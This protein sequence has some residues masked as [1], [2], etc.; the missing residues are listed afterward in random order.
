MPQIDV[1]TGQAALFEQIQ[2]LL[3]VNDRPAIVVRGPSGSG[4]TWLAQAVARS[5][6]D[7]GHVAFFA[8]GDDVF[9]RRA[10]FPL[11]VA[12]A[13]E[14]G[15]EQSK[16]AT[17]VALAPVTVI[18]FGG[19]PLREILAHF[20]E[21]QDATI[22][23]KTPHLRQEDREIFLRMQRSAGENR[24][25][26]VCD[27]VQ[28]WDPTSLEWLTL[29]TSG[30]L[31]AVF[32][33]LD[34]LAVLA[35]RTDESRES[36]EVDGVFQSHF[37]H[38]LSLPLCQQPVFPALLSAFGISRPLPDDVVRHLFT[39]TGS[40]LELVRRIAETESS[41]Q[42]TWSEM[43]SRQAFLFELLER[44]LER[45]TD[46]P[47]DTTSVL[48][49]AAII[50]L[51]FSEHELSCLLAGREKL[52]VALEPAERLRLLE[53]SGPIRRFVHDLVREYYL[54]GSETRVQ[55]LHGRFSECLRLLHSGDFAR[56]AEHLRRAGDRR[57]TGNLLILEYLRAL[58][59]G[60]ALPVE[61]LRDELDREQLSFLTLMYEA[62]RSF[63][64]GGYDDVLRVL[65]SIEELHVDALL[66][67][68]DILAA[69]AH[70]KRLGRVD[71]EQANRILQRWTD[72][73]SSEPDV[74]A[75][76]MIYRV[77]ASVFLADEQ[78]AHDSERAL[79][80]EL[81]RRATYD[82]TA[83]RTINHLRLKSNM[84][85]SVHVARERLQQAIEFF[86]GIGEGATLDPVHQAV[87]LVNLAA[88]Y[89]VEGEY[90]QAFVACHRAEAVLQ[91]EPAMTFPRP[92]I[93]L[94]NMVVSGYLSGNV[95]A[96]DALD[97]ATS[98]WRTFGRNNDGP[99]LAANVGYFLA[100]L[101]RHEDV[102]KQLEPVF[103]GLVAGQVID[104][105]YTYFVGNNLSG[106]LFEVGRRD[107]SLET[108]NAIA[109]FM[110]E[111]IGPSAPYLRR[112]HELQS[113][114]FSG[115]AVGSWDAFLS[116]TSPQVGPGWSY[117]GRGFLP[118]ELE[119]WSDE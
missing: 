68:R 55:E 116:A 117:Y 46:V 69:R 64:A 41:G 42:A 27:N 4:K 22:V 29:A 90:E 40:H 16:A 9:A 14:T 97:T 31:G 25:L 54:G 2:H 58:R 79:Y 65:D 78:Q 6:A 43:D 91:S 45:L 114:V 3:L 66:A 101:G 105:Y 111:T 81:S 11:L 51:S 112:R 44:R 93:L 12:V 119:F 109:P 60:A 7:A 28:S 26:L 87:G 56:R 15:R 5:W 104:P 24:C 96:A 107:E 20:F 85:H 47:E 23:A 67:E 10:L 62:H 30:S 73:R 52:Q 19:R 115:G 108:W 38:E 102:V 17:R 72:L 95:T 37:W 84:L 33:F 86:G 1:I 49:A 8:R 77:V 76:T 83:R 103:R 118:C 88:N 36:P 94:T 92:D 18:P 57:S 80:R 82:F 99:L 74:W 39:V 75:R 59:A 53:R 71:R 113:G 34:R 50:G 13:A 35:T 70:I 98:T 100:M 63:D 106:A 110:A 32:P 48:R 61:S 89:V 21:R